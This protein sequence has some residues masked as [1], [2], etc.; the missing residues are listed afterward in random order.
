MK[1]TATIKTVRSGE[2]SNQ[3]RQMFLAF[4]GKTGL[5]PEQVTARKLQGFKAH[6]EM[7]AG[8]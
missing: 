4:R 5:A 8:K 2:Y 6:F 7:M 1:K 3:A